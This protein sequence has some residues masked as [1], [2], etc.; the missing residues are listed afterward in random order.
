MGADLY[1]TD[2]VGWTEQQARLLRAA[3]AER[4]NL[5]LDWDHLAGEVE[6]RGKS[7]RRA[8]ASLVATVIEH[9]QTL[10]C[11]PAREPRR[12]WLASVLRARA[13][14][15][16]RLADEPGLRPRLP[17][18]VAEQMPRTAALV[19]RLLQ[20]AGEPTDGIAARLTE[21]GYTPEQ[22]TGDWLPPDQAP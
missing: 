20:A 15:E 12:G 6:D 5:G 9:L 21:G 8:R 7:Y 3:A 19:T 10:E 2:F 17:G 14:I 18:I 4:T 1:E 13:E 22:V 16:S 11:S